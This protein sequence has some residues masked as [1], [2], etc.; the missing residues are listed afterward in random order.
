MK[1]KGMAARCVVQTEWCIG[2]LRE[3]LEIARDDV[4]CFAISPSYPRPSCSSCTIHVVV[5]LNAIRNE[6]EENGHEKADD[7]PQGGDPIDNVHGTFSET[8]LTGMKNESNREKG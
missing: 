7:N 2:T 4:R 5:M 6:A 1:Q 8:R 3:P